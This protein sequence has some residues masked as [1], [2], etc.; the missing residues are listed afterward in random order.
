MTKSILTTIDLAA[1]ASWK[2]ALPKA[3]DLARFYKAE[4]HV[5]Y[6]LPV[7]GTPLVAEFFPPDFYNKGIAR[8]K[9]DLETLAAAQIPDDVSVKLHLRHGNVHEEVLALIDECGA[10]LVVMASH[11]PGSVRE[12]LVGSQA[13]RVVRRSPVSVLVVR[14]PA[15]Q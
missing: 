15:G 6:V 5:V 14:N 2:T 4:L 9:A 8:A 11:A 7:L 10:D 12:F 13:D 3:V 1:D